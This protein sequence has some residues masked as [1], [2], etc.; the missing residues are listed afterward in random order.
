LWKRGVKKI[1][2]E[3]IE[4]ILGYEIEIVDWKEK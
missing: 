4:A 2:K 1:T 3:E